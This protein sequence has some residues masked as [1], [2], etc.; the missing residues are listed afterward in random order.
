MLSLGRQGV[1]V[2]LPFAGAAT[3][4]A[5]IAADTGVSLS[6]IASDLRLLRSAD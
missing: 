2:V 6:V 3:L 4:W 1:F 5:A